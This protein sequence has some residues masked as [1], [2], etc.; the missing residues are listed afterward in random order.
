MARTDKIRAETDI[1]SYP[2]LI[3]IGLL[4]YSGSQAAAVSGLTDFFQV[5]SYLYAQHNRAT[6]RTFRVSHWRWNTETQRCEHIFDTHPQ[7]EPNTSLAAL[8]LPPSLGLPPHDLPAVLYADWIKAQHRS[9]TIVCSICAAAFLLAET[10]LLEGRPATTHWLHTDDF[11]L[12]FPNVRV[13]TSRLLIDDGDII[14]AG[15]VMAWIDLGLNLIERFLGPS[16]MLA[17]ARYFLV[18]AAGREQRFYA[19]FQPRFGH[20]DDAI[21]KVQ[22]WLQRSYAENL[23]ITAMASHANLSERTFLRR[24]QSATGAKPMEYVQ[25]LRINK[26]REELELTQ[27]TVQEIAWKVGYGDSGAF[28]RAFHR[29]VGLSPREYRSRFQATM[30]SSDVYSGEMLLPSA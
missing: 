15:G 12:R 7:D 24:F 26:A 29:I 21:L 25:R 23:S 10:G 20:G 4:A 19:L 22:H 2:Q 16:T 30:S 18:D 3:D 9:G 28:R 14:T 6:P 11:A 8:I 17:T 13:D 1:S 5:A 27:S